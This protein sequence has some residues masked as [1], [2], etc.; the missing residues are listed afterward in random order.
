MVENLKFIFVVSQT[1]GNTSSFLRAARSG[2]LDKVIE[3]LK[4]KIDINTSNSVS[5]KKKLLVRLV[6][7]LNHSSYCF[8]DSQ[9]GLNALHLAS[10]DGHLDI[11]KELLK[12]GANV[13]SAT[14]KGNTALHI[15]SLGMCPLFIGFRSIFQVSTW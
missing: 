14:K 5:V 13:N 8:Y 2:N 9:N 4:N 15:A 3:H 1:E 6:V 10:K 11:V 12:R 7:F